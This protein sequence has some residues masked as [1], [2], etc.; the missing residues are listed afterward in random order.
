MV[1][2]GLGGL[3]AAVLLWATFRV[4]ARDALAA[5]DLMG[6][7]AVVLPPELYAAA[8]SSAG[9]RSASSAAWSASGRVQM[10]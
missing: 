1:Q 7:A 4:V 5:T 9:W 3:V 2:G 6:Q 10:W 8:S